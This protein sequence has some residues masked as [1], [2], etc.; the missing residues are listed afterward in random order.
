MRCYKLEARAFADSVIILNGD[1]D[2]DNNIVEYRAFTADQLA[3]L[4]VP[5]AR[6]GACRR[7]LQSIFRITRARRNLDR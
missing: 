7:N 4:T 5:P 2:D 6:L 1:V 3:T